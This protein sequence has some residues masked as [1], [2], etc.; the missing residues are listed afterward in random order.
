MN[1]PTNKDLFQELQALRRFVEKHL[2]DAVSNQEERVRREL[3][4]QR[5]KLSAAKAAAKAAGREGA[6]G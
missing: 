3:K 6:T 1:L 4:A 5:R 2:P